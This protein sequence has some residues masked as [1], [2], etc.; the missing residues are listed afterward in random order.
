LPPRTPVRLTLWSSLD[1]GTFPGPP[2]PTWQTFEVPLVAFKEVEPLWS[3][4]DLQEVRFRF[5]RTPRGGLL[6]DQVGFRP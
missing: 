1:A 3:P 6:V 4:R 2:P 5:D